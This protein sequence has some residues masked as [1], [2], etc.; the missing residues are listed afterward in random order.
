VPILC[1]GVYFV[2]V[3]ERLTLPFLFVRV[4]ALVCGAH[5]EQ[6]KYG[7]NTVA[8]ATYARIRERV[9]RNARDSRSR[10]QPQIKGPRPLAG[11]RAVQ[12]VNT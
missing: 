4:V 8:G 3:D 6:Q 10:S 2:S 12:T 1:V 7:A 5:G 11:T 9:E